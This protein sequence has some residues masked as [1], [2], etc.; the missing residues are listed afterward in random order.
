MHDMLTLM[1]DSRQIVS[2]KFKIGALPF[3][4][5]CS[6]MYTS[7]GESLYYFAAPFLSNSRKYCDRT[8]G[9]TEA[10]ERHYG[11]V[12]HVVGVEQFGLQWAA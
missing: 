1:I 3:C 7:A 2:T 10:V 11:N 4:S 6:E 12:I 5:F 8:S 9:V